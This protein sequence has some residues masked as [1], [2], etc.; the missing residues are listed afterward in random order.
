MTTTTN[1]DKN[2]ANIWGFPLRVMYNQFRLKHSQLLKYS[3]IYDVDIPVLCMKQHI[4]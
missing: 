2:T 3:L 4:Q 1:K